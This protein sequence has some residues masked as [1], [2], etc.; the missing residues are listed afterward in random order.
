M[1]DDKQIA[2]RLI[3]ANDT[4]QLRAFIG[5]IDF[6]SLRLHSGGG[7]YETPLTIAAYRGY[8]KTVELLLERRGGANPNI[9]NA[10]GKAPIEVIFENDKTP[11]ATKLAILSLLVNA[12]AK[13]TRPREV[14]DLLKICDQT[15]SRVY[16]I[17]QKVCK[18]NPH[19]QGAHGYLKLLEDKVLRAKLT[20]PILENTL[21]S[22]L[23]SALID[24][25]ICEYSGVPKEEQPKPQDI[26]NLLDSYR[27][28]PWA[29]GFGLIAL[30][31]AAG[32]VTTALLAKDS[33]SVPAYCYLIVFEI[34]MTFGAATVAFGASVCNPAFAPLEITQAG[35]RP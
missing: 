5:K 20:R 35:Q 14:I 7:C 28:L 10:L 33:L 15:D 25:G 11:I 17:L 12:G 4:E 30:S 31:A 1:T 23:P 8:I 29:R 6:D 22:I 3:L 13:I 34:L 9:C 24:H 26:E 19:Y 21:S 18:E 32:T 2:K 27:F 16:T